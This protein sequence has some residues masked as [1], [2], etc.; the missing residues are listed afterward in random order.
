[1]MVNVIYVALFADRSPDP[2]TRPASFDRERV[3]SLAAIW[4]QNLN[5]GDW[6]YLGVIPPVVQKPEFPNERFARVGYV[7]ARHYDAGLLADFLSAYHG[8]LPWNVL[9]DEG[10]YD[11][12]LA[13]GVARPS[14]AVVL[15]AAERE[16]FRAR[17][18]AARASVT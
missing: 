9:H 1:M 12:L 3:V 13:P 7:G 2:L 16:E 14:T 8:F 18:A 15:G 4:R 17:E 5:R 11:Q 10:F 6:K